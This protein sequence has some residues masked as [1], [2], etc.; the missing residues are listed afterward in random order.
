MTRVVCRELAIPGV[1][2][3][4]QKVFQDPRGFFME[5][6]NREKYLEAGISE[7]FA[8]DNCSH[9]LHG[10]LRG[11]HY[12]L[13][14]PQAKLVTLLKGRILDV[15]VDIRRGSPTFGKWV[16]QVISDMDRRQ[17]YIPKGFAHGFCVLSEEADVLYK[18]TDLYYPEDDHGVLWCDPDIGIE[19][20]LEHPVLSAKDGKLRKLSEI[21]P[22]ELPL[23]DQEKKLHDQ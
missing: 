4:E 10:V 1:L 23:F 11:L 13:K 8:Q 20:P 3:I 2:L 7:S 18:C 9:S 6:Y 15:A 22:D 16:S 17:L 14:H 5:S 21:P 19:W 12:Q